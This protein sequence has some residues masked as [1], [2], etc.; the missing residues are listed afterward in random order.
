VFCLAALPLLT[1]GSVS[2]REP[3]PLLVL[4]T[5]LATH[6][7]CCQLYAVFEAGN[8]EWLRFRG[9]S[10]AWSPTTQLL[11]YVRNHRIWIG[12]LD[13]KERPLA[14]GNYQASQPTWAR[15]GKQLAFA[16]GVGDRLR[17]R[18]RGLCVVPVAAGD[19][20][21]VVWLRDNRVSSPSWSPKGDLIAFSRGPLDAIYTVRP[22]GTGLG[23]LT[24]LWTQ[25][26]PQWSRL[27]RWTAG[28][29]RISYI[30]ETLT[31]S[32]PVGDR[33]AF[34]WMRPDGSDKE[35]VP[36]AH[37]SR[38]CS[39]VTDISWS[40]GGRSL[41]YAVEAK[42]CYTTRIGRTPAVSLIRKPTRGCTGLTWL[43]ARRR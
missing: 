30:H 36:N 31:R 4:S 43:R 6:R 39:S 17:D 13:G 14:Q 16:C 24:P 10:P 29:A 5:R 1:A 7:G 20:R 22:D 37:M 32:R 38:P 25:A 12:S 23:R 40:P 33:C 41:A 8:G 26:N 18:D 9:S 42:Y 3:D 28:G 21:R 2:E 15:D 34:L 27:P 35:Y 19:V 11:A